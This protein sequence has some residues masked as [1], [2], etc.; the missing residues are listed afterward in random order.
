MRIKGSL[1][2]NT[3]A[4]LLVLGFLAGCET[5]PP[6]KPVVKDSHEGHDHGHEK[7]A[8]GGHVHG[9]NGGE[10]VELEGEGDH[11]HL[12]WERNDE[13]GLVTFYLLDKDSK[14]LAESDAAEITIVSKVGDKETTYNLPRA[15]S[16]SETKKTTRFEL[17][18]KALATALTADKGVT[19]TAKISIGGKP[20]TGN[21]KHDPEHDHH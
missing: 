7:E 14:N 12:E 15:S 20:Y 5:S 8:E 3:G 21:V 2:L 10:V 1:W 13:T 11:Y 18:D 6:S 9:P 17:E 19:N 4:A 16:E